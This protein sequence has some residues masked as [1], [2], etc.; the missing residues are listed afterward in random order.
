MILADVRRLRRRSRRTSTGSAAW[1]I[2][3]DPSNRRFAGSGIH[4]HR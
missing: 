4:H 2:S 3:A 1:S